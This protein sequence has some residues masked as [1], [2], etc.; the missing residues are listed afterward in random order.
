[1]RLFPRRTK[2]VDVSSNAVTA[3]T[4]RAGTA[5]AGTM[6]AG[7]GEGRELPLA[8]VSGLDAFRIKAGIGRDRVTAVWDGRILRLSEQLY[9]LAEMATAIDD[10]SVAAGLPVTAHRSTL[11]CCPEGAML[12][13]I[14][15]CDTLQRME[16]SYAGRRRLL[17]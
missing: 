10:V 17:V 13:L 9:R 3:G 15:C 2:K 16:Y 12:T 8:R 4:V 1:M 5:R 11:S 6:R 14:N 7:T